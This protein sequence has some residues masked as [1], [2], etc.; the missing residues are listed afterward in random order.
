MWNELLEIRK[1]LYNKISTLLRDTDSVSIIWFSGKGQYG[2]LVED[3]QVKSDT[4]LKN[5]KN[6]LIHNLLHV[7]LQ[8]SVNH[9]KKLRP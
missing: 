9:Y 1:D 4:S 7:D 8:H 2:V 5:L 3:F 6:L